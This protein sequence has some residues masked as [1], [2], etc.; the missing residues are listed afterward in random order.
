VEETAIH[1]T[2]APTEALLRKCRSNLEHGLTPIV[3]TIAES[4]A[5]ME[6][7]ARNVDLDSRIDVLEAEQFIAANLHEWTLFDAKRRR[8]EIHRLF[9]RYNAIV[10]EVETDPSLRIEVS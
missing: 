3:V 6:S 5:G 7:L 1:V 9:A 2:T 10:D 8:S 4:R